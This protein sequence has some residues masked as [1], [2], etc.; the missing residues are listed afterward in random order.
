MILKNAVLIIDTRGVYRGKHD[1][2]V[3]A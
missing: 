2:V 3:C 1:A